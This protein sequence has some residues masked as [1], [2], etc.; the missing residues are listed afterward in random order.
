MI[1]DVEIQIIALR[2]ID[3]FFEVAPEDIQHLVP[4]LLEQVLPALSHDV[5]DVRQAANKVNASLIDYIASLSEDQ[6][7]DGEQIA[8]SPQ[9]QHS[10]P[11]NRKDSDDNTV[12]KRSDDIESVMSE[13]LI[14]GRFAMKRI[15]LER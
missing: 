6:A 3:G 2:W 15:A 5:D 12:N 4:Q 1:V 10:A 11:T 14:C 8:L 9:D 13:W 7:K